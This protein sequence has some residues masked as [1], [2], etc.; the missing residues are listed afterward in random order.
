MTLELPWNTTMLLPTEPITISA[1]ASQARRGVA[2]SS[3]LRGQ[4]RSPC[5]AAVPIRVPWKVND[6]GQGP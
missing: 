4:T 6:T 5:V 1:K 2:P 3:K